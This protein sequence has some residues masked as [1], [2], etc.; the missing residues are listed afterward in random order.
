MKLL[1]RLPI[2]SAAAALMFSLSA[3]L[4]APLLA[5]TT[6]LDLYRLGE[7][8]PGAASG[9]TGNA[10]TIDA[11]GPNNL[12]Q[13]GAPTYTNDTI[14]Y[15]STLAMKFDGTDL[16]PQRYSLGSNVSSALDNF[17]IEALVRADVT[18]F[19]T[20]NSSLA[21]NGS[22]G[23]GGGWGLFRSGS[24]YVGLFGGITFVGSGIVPA[25]PGAWTHLALVRDSGTT[26]LY[27]EGVAV[28]T[29]GTAP[30]GPAASFFVGGNVSNT[31][32]FRGAIDNV[33]VFTFTPGNFNPATDLNVGHKN[34]AGYRLGE[35]DPGALNG[36][37]GQAQT[38][39]LFG[40]HHLTK[41][42]AAQTYTNATAGGGTT[43]GMDFSGAAGESYSTNV[44]STIT[45][46]FRL[47]AW[48]ASDVDTGNAIV[49]YNGSTSNAGYG[50]FRFGN[51]WTALYGGVVLQGFG[52][53]VQT[54]VLTHLVL[55]RENGISRFFIDG[56]QV[57]SNF[58]QVPNT[59]AGQFMIGGNSIAGNENFDGRI[60]EVRLVQIPEPASALLL[61]L[62]ALVVG[63]VSRSRH[64][65]TH[66]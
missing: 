15:Q 36:A 66:G 56:T 28:A 51:E 18:D 54:G 3:S 40:G 23:G 5:A 45:D 53:T 58:F 7:N 64:G 1:S 14:A 12:A 46:N 55:E 33:R 22:S 11:V 47:E 8:D 39:D 13:T 10:T 50:I 52:A 41:N 57:G 26:T 60:D 21:Y 43:L 59:P 35:N 34:I 25:V 24:T 20:A 9:N 62:G 48:A 30:V 63:R 61:A 27:A 37:A 38:I 19:A 2:R 49:A 17:G 42:G 32:N 31:E 29:T 6:T 65:R 4:A 44:F 16:L